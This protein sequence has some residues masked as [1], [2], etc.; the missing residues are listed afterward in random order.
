M[1]CPCADGYTAGNACRTYLVELIGVEE[2]LH[3]GVARTGFLGNGI[4][5]VRDFLRR[6]MIVQRCTQQISADQFV[7]LAANDLVQLANILEYA[8][9][10]PA[11]SPDSPFSP[12]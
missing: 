6:I 7:S 8:P 3:V 5:H 10:T 11:I 1:I 4:C 2:Q 12:A 9:H